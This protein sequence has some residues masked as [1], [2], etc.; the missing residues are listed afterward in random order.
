MKRVLIV[1]HKIE[2]CGVQKFGK[3]I[4]DIVGKDQSA[5]YGYVEAS[6]ITE[7]K[8]AVIT[9]SPDAIVYNWYSCTMPW[10]S[11]ETVSKDNRE[12][13]FIYHDGGNIRQHFDYYLFFGAYPR[14]EPVLR[15]KSILLPRPLFDYSTPEINN[16]VLSIGSFGFGQPHKG[17]DDLVRYVNEHYSKAVINIHMTDPYFGDRSGKTK[18]I[19]K[20][21]CVKLNT[22]QGITLNITDNFMSDSDM[23]DF[24]AKNDINVFLYKGSSE[25][26]S[27]VVDYALS[28][29][30]PIALSNN[31]M[32]KH[33]YKEEIDLS[34][35][36]LDEILGNG[37]K[38]LEEYYNK[39]STRSFKGEFDAIFE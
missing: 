18:D 29:K 30:R 3:R 11:E 2:Q 6:N 10:L 33:V 31:D 27:S 26:L 22:N 8:D 36:P 35:H 5:S 37:T 25:G 19:I 12:H 13:Y 39:W 1:N 17:F 9:F 28:V 32:F 24:L 14:T 23:L 21:M 4:F 7:Y 20:D 15:D 34:L 38:P 16:N